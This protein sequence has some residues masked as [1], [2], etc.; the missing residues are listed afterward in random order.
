MRLLNAMLAG[1][2]LAV[3]PLHAAEPAST[4]MAGES[5]LTLRVDGELTI[6]TEG[7]VLSYTLR[8]K[9]DQNLQ[10]LLAKAI[11]QWRLVPMQ[12][13]GK[14]VNATSPM[15][16]TLAAKQIPAGY[17][18]RVDNVIFRALNNADIA[19]EKAAM[20]RA[21]A[22]GEVVT[23]VG[24]APHAPVLIDSVKMRPPGYPIGLVKAGVEGVVLL[25]LRLNPDGTVAEVLATQSSLFDI[26]GNPSVL[27]KARGL[28][29]KESVQ[30]AKTWTFK[31]D[32]EKTAQLTHEDLTLVVPVE[33]VMGTHNTQELNLTEKWRQEFRGPNLPTP[34]LKRAAQEVGVS[35][36]AG[37]EQVAGTATFQLRDRSILNRAL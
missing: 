1:V 16:I 34:W 2:L 4:A 33:F 8:S 15:R 13:G 3:T 29:E 7:Q 22:T 18:V 28:L 30:A 11:P 27:D 32:A 35:D 21:R 36:L 14:P 31:I 23:Q 5:V 20:A 10:N 6:G 9:V 17:E 26:K 12:Q 37:G 24:E 19:V 25:N